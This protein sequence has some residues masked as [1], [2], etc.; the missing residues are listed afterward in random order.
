MKNSS[1]T[2]RQVEKI[3][4]VGF[5]DK[6]EVLDA[7]QVQSSGPMGEVERVHHLCYNKPGFENLS[8]SVFDPLW[9]Q[10]VVNTYEVQYINK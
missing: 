2:R 8:L 10:T 9:M 1:R 6:T 4:S 5:M 7:P 3:D